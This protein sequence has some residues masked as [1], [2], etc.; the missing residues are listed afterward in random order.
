MTFFYES[1]IFSE[2]FFCKIIF[3]AFS[4]E[5]NLYEVQEVEWC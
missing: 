4:L 5:I 1:E 2:I 3:E